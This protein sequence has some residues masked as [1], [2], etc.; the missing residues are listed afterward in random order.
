MCLL[1]ARLYVRLKKRALAVQWY[2]RLLDLLAEA[3]PLVH[4]CLQLCFSKTY[5]CV[6]VFFL[7]C[8][9]LCH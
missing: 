2:W 9:W 1:Y 8:Q 5:C 7:C 4:V 3:T 6:R